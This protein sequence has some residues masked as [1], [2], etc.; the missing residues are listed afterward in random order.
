MSVRLKV[1]LVAALISAAMF[2]WV[3]QT[4]RLKKPV[5]LA[6]LEVP[7]YQTVGKAQPSPTAPLAAETGQGEN[8]VPQE[9]L[10]PWEDPGLHQ[11][12][13]EMRARQR[14]PAE[15]DKRAQIQVLQA[16][17]QAQLAAGDALD[18]EAVGESIGRLIEVHGS[19]VVGG[20][21]LAK[22]QHNVQVAAQISVLAKE[23]E[24]VSETANPAA[25]EGYSRRL[26]ALQKQL[27]TDVY[28][29]GE[30]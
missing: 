16:E 3:L 6:P 1:L 17:L 25:L 21:D 7:Q 28:V 26:E 15:L 27:V 13:V 5:A 23:M 29:S 19:P 24:G 2:Y 10:P 8:R 11:E 4:T 20:V 22:V 9:V 12:V 18:I 30:G 14:L